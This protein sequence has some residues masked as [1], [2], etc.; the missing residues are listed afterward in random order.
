MKIIS[1]PITLSLLLAGAASLGFGEVSTYTFTGAGTSGDGDIPTSTSLVFTAFDYGPGIFSVGDDDVFGADGFTS[2]NVLSSTDYVFFTVSSPSG[3]TLLE[4]L[5]FEA[6]SNGGPF[7]RDHLYQTELLINGVQQ[8]ISPVGNLDN[9]SGFFAPF[10]WDFADVSISSSD[11]A[12]F[13]I[14]A[15][16][17]FTRFSVDNV[18]LTHSAAIPEASTS[19]MIAGVLF[20][21]LVWIRR[22]RQG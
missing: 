8:E 11:T 10:S 22:I 14:Y 1:R 7:G 17:H 4:S 20:A 12:E 5:D 15:D 2:D 19:A 21:G 9:R 13:R 6:S 3:S 16:P 18:A